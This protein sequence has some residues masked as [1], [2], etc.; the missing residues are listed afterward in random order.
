ML[1]VEFI[2]M[3]FIIEVLIVY[4]LE[5][6]HW[7]KLD[8]S[9][10]AFKALLQGKNGYKDAGISYGL[11]VAPKINFC[12]TINNYGDIDERITFTGF[13]NVSDN[14]DRKEYFK[15]FNGD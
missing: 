6:K 13:T 4:L 10:L 9:G 7:D 3:M 2:Q 14:F 1:L 11:C 8:K 5:I 15:M 12:L